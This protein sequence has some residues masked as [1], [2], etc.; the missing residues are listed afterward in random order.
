MQRKVNDCVAIPKLQQ[1][2][3]SHLYHVYIRSSFE[4]FHVGKTK[5]PTSTVDPELDQEIEVS[6]SPTEHS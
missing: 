5:G 2:H 3:L 6:L 1:H 4:A